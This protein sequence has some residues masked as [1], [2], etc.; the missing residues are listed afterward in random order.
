MSFD[1]SG[2][3]RTGRE[4]RGGAPRGSGGTTRRRHRP[5]VECRED[6]RLLSAITEFP[7]PK[8][9]SYPGDLTVVHRGSGGPIGTPCVSLRSGSADDACGRQISER[10]TE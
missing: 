8:A 7:L 9:V 2:L 1:S 3:L 6:R 4:Q 10:E 5:G